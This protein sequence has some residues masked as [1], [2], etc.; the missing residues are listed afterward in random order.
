MLLTGVA[1]PESKANGITRRNAYKH[2]LLHGLRDGGNEKANADRG[3]QEQPEAG[4]K[5]D[6]RSDKGNAK[7]KLRDQQN[8]GRLAQA[9]GHVGNAPFPP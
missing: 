2:C 4:I 6:K 8:G 7:P 3:H 1:R 5:H 9:D